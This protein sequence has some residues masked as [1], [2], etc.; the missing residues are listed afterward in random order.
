MGREAT[1][2]YPDLDLVWRNDS[3][4]GALVKTSF[5]DNDITVTIY[6]DREGKVVKEENG[7]PE[8]SVGPSFDTNDEA[9]CI[10]V[11]EVIQV[12]TVEIPC[13][14]ADE[15][16]DPDGECASLRPGEKVKA[17]DG[18]EG[19]VVELWRVITQPGREPTRER[20]PWRYNMF[21]TK[22]LVGSGPPPTTT[23]TVPGATTTTAPAATTSTTAPAN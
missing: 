14:K 17:G 9:R 16:D 7:D 19:Y 1:V 10:N 4:H 3:D 13:D 6:G 21:P 8:C 12:E 11:L 5:T 23:T 20:F 22:I 2:N 18:H 15:L